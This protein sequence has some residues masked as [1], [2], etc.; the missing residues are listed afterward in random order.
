MTVP[1][2]PGHAKWACQVGESIFRMKV[3]DFLVCPAWQSRQIHGFD[4]DIAYYLVIYLG[5]S[6]IQ[7]LTQIAPK[8]CVPPEVGMPSEPQVGTL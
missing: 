3:G 7:K 8:V 6:R 2:R 1:I 4:H 5:G